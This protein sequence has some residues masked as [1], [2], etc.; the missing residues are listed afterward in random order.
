MHI[1]SALTR[2]TMSAGSNRATQEEDRIFGAL[3]MGGAKLLGTDADI[4]DEELTTT[5]I[6]VIITC[7]I[8]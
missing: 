6:S 3:A 2:P 1:S 8:D 7:G 5:G 4:S